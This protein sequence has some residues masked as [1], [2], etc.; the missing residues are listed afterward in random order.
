MAE[1]GAKRNGTAKQSSSPNWHDTSFFQFS[2]A[3]KGADIAKNAIGGFGNV[4][5]PIDNLFHALDENTLTAAKD[6]DG[7]LT[8]GV[9]H[10]DTQQTLSY[11]TN[12]EDVLQRIHEAPSTEPCTRILRKH[13]FT[14]SDSTLLHYIAAKGRMK[15]ILKEVLQCGIN[16]G[17]T[18]DVLDQ[19]HLTPLQVAIRRSRYDNVVALLDFG[20]SVT[21]TGP[22]G[23]LPLHTAITCCKDA[24]IVKEIHGR[25]EDGARK[26]VLSPS[27]REGQVA[28]DLVISRLLEEDPDYGEA[29][30]A[31]ETKKILIEIIKTTPTIVNTTF[32]EQ[33][34]DN[35]WTLFLRAT[36][37]ISRLQICGDLVVTMRKLANER[38]HNDPN[39][40]WYQYVKHA[41]LQ[42]H[43]N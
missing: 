27:K 13:D 19:D 31:Q 37:A 35:K 10:E 6:L 20:A 38:E 24:R 26:Q 23:E 30:C 14:S 42:G 15:D 36:T 33:H 12:F 8:A 41:L 9:H 3:D 18:V 7:D 34:A 11:A 1:W 2:P 21:S 5:P 43:L 17:F 4:T 28:L 22:D 39:R 40:Y 16:Y 32:L 29:I 25:F